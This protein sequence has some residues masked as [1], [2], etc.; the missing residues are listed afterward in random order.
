M[1]SASTRGVTTM[2]SGSFRTAHQNDQNDADTQSD[3]TDLMAYFL[4]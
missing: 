3:L 2:D 1:H 4:E